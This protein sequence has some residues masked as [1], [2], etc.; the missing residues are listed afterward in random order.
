MMIDCYN[1][2][3]I[4][5]GGERSMWRSVEGR[6]IPI[7]LNGIVSIFAVDGIRMPFFSYTEPTFALSQNM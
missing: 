7:M 3:K 2:S 6:S 4:K 5:N 1:F